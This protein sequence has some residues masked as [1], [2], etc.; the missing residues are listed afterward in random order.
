M[1]LRTLRLPLLH[2]ASCPLDD[3]TAFFFWTPAFCAAGPG[4]GPSW[5]LRRY[6]VPHAL[7]SMGFSGGPRRHWGDS[8]APQCM[9]GPP[10]LLLLENTGVA[11]GAA[12]GVAAGTAAKLDVLPDRPCPEAGVSVTDSLDARAG[13]AGALGCSASLAWAVVAM[14]TNEAPEGASRP[15]STDGT[16]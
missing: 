5:L 6:R 9:Q 12:A 7:H 8:V 3:A 11:A 2:R 14:D 4:T 13:G 15:Q 16:G 1:L 10:N